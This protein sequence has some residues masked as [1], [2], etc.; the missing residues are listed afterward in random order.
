MDLIRCCYVFLVLSEII[1]VSS[2][3]VQFYSRVI[4]PGL[5]N[6]I[7]FITKHFAHVLHFFARLNR[8][9]I[10]FHQV[11]YMCLKVLKVQHLFEAK[12]TQEPLEVG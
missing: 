2:Q 6:K 4:Y 5:D 8:Q 9:L 12:G 1:H 11:V 10:V 3:L 7:P